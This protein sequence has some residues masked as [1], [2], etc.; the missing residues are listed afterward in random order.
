MHREPPLAIAEP[1]IL[2]LKRQTEPTTPTP[3]PKRPRQDSATKPAPDTPP[4]DLPPPS[5][6][7]V[8]PATNPVAVPTPLSFANMPPA[9]QQDFMEK[10]LK[11][12]SEVGRGVAILQKAHADA[13]PQEVILQMKTDL[14]KKFE[15]YKRFAVLLGPKKPPPSTG[16]VLAPASQPPPPGAAVPTSKTTPPAESDSSNSLPPALGSIRAPL[17]S[18]AATEPQDPNPTL[19]TMEPHPTETVAPIHRLMQQQNQQSPVHQGILSQIY[20]PSSL[21]PPH[22]RHHTTTRGKQ[23]ERDPSPWLTTTVA[24]DVLLGGHE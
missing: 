14:G 22:R 9:K 20:H 4:C 3:E 19:P 6:G 5:S 1:S 12:Q 7:P 17:P 2:G 11:L 21:S 18:T 16:A 8:T 23:T 13:T 10:Y 15:L 24:W